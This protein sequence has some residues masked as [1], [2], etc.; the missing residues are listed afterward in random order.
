MAEKAPIVRVLEEDENVIHAIVQTPI[1]EVTLM[2]NV[3]RDPHRLV[4]NQIHV[5]GKGLTRAIIKR[6]AK[7]L[8][9]AEGVEDVVLHG[10]V[11]TSGANP[12]STPK[13]IYVKVD[14]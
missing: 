11:R 6:A 13:P 8:G 3:I 7:E 12:G 9:L 14:P 4:L 2:A 1:G 10:G 5:E